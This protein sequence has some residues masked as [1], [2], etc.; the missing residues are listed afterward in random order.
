MS[1]LRAILVRPL[2][3]HDD[4]D[5]TFSIDVPQT[6]FRL[7]VGMLLTGDHVLRLYDDIGLRKR[8]LHVSSANPVAR[9]Q[10]ALEN[11]LGMYLDAG[12][13]RM[14]LRRIGLQ[15]S[16]WII[17]HRQIFVIHANPSKGLLGNGLVLSHH[18]CHLITHEADHVRAQFVSP[19]PTQH[20]LIGI[21]QPIL[22]DRNIRRRQDCQH[23][24][25]RLCLTDVHS[26]HAGVRS[27]RKKHLHVELAFHVNVA[28]I[29]GLT[30]DL[31]TSINTRKACSDIVTFH[32]VLLCVSNL[33][34]RRR[35]ATVVA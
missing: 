17:D 10:I 32:V 34:M 22:I 6:G 3:T 12:I 33:R 15:G 2:P 19:R 31:A 9:D 26:Q 16:P 4:R 1:N 24:G 30:H 23:A 13:G 21:L 8:G 14:Q 18:H 28:W 25:H 35:T 20:R 7:Q 5:P 27:A 29:G 11:Q